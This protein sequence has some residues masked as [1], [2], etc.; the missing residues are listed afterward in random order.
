MGGGYITGANREG[1]HLRGVEPGRDF[2]FKRGD[3]RSVEAGDT[4]NGSP[5]RIEPAI[6]VGNIF[7]L[8]TRYSE[9]L[10]ASYLDESG[11]S[12]PIWMGSYGLGPA[13]L[14]AAAV[15]Q[16]ADEQGISWPASMAP[17]DVHLV[18]LGKRRQRGARSSPSASTRSC[19]RR[20]SRS[21]YDD[22]DCRPGGEVRGRRAA[23]SPAAPDR[24]PAHARLGRGRGAGPPRAARPAPSRSRAPR[25]RRWSCGATSRE[26]RRAWRR[27]PDRARGRPGRGRQ[28]AGDGRARAADVPAPRGPGP[29]GPAAAADARRAAAEAVDDPERDRLRPARAGPGLPG[30][31]V[32]LRRR[33]EPHRGD[34]LRRRRLERL[35]R[36]DRRADHRPVLA[37]GGAAGPGSST[38][39]W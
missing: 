36:R 20:A 10:G 13:R 18:G 4:V 9:P 34:H 25:T 39:C 29:L 8:G 15:E 6:E 38:G 3:V 35:P 30:V 19:A 21:I 7:K 32:H 1:A 28:G 5:I 12:K 37:P 27:P 14:A 24:R 31:R 17:F 33:R 11:Q 26:R 22:R 2:P 16:Y 23:R